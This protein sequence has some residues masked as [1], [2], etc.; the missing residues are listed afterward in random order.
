MSPV[1]LETLYNE[2][3]NDDSL[4]MVGSF[5]RTFLERFSGVERTD[6]IELPLAHDEIVEKL[7]T[8][9]HGLSH[10]S[11]IIRKSMFER[12]GPYDENPFASDSFWSAKLAEYARHCPDVRFKNVPAFLTLCRIHGANQTQVLSTVDPRNRRTRFRQYCECKLRKIREQAAACP[13][14]DV[15]A[16]LRACDCSD[17]L[18]RFKA[19]I[20]RWE[21]EPVPPEARQYLLNAAEAL[22]SN[23]SYVSCVS[24]LNGIETMDRE[25]PQRFLN[26]D[27]LK[28]MALYALDAKESSLSRLHR[29]IENHDNPAAREFLRD[30]FE[31]G[32]TQDVQEWCAEHAAQFSLAIKET[33]C[34]GSEAFGSPAGASQ[35]LERCL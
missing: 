11:A 8:W 33:R 10:G 25:I 32:R 15:A 7:S 16:E 24:F 27:L 30:L 1:K 4:A 20:I 21:S 23:R 19:Q 17:F 3:S 5:Y 22:F 12:I 31:R 6:P 35:K 34:S 13:T 14:L 26:F 18:T 9:H 28:A 2:I 29:E